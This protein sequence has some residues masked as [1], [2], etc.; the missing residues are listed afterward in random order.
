ME[1]I[2]TSLVIRFIWIITSLI[3]LYWSIGG[4]ER[5]S[6]LNSG[7]YERNIVE[8]VLELIVEDF[9]S[10]EDPI[11]KNQSSDTDKSKTVSIVEANDFPPFPPGQIYVFKL[12]KIDITKIVVYKE[13]YKEQHHPENTP[14]PPK[15]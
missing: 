12:H 2:R 10:L 14:P 5:E 9:L 3:I 6:Q 11:K 15:V 8:N 7:L 1:F 13:T 4:P